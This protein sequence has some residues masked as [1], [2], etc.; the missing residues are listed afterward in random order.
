[1]QPDAIWNIDNISVFLDVA[2]KKSV[3]S[4]AVEKKRIYELYNLLIT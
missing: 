2:H 4:R 1:M 3:I